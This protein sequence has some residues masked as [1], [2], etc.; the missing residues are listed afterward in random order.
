MDF[1][2]L[3]RLAVFGRRDQAQPDEQENAR[4]EDISLR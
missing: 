1:G 2:P 3:E 4:H